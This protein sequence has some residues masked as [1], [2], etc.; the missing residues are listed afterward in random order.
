MAQ[1]IRRFVTGPIETNCYMVLDPDTHTAV[2]IDPGP[3]A[4]EHLSHF[5]NTGY[6]LEAILLTH[7]HWDHI[8]SA[9]ALHERFGAPRILWE[10]ERVTLSDPA[11]NCSTLLSGRAET[12][13]ADRFLRDREKI[14]AAGCVFECR[15]TP[16]HTPGGC[17]YYAEAHQVLFSGDSIFQLSYG[18]TDFP[19]GSEDALLDSIQR[20]TEDL[21]DETTILP[22][23]GPA[24]KLGF[25]RRNNGGFS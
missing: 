6:R 3:G 13:E 16:G 10:K 2:V 9:A 1:E 23:H 8:A 22:G 18:R 19:G 17:M 14:T 7:A 11:M 15:G 12:Y 5:G 21:P 25:E 24:T 4:D 20:N